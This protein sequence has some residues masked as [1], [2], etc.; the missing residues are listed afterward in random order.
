MARRINF[1]LC[2]KAHWALKSGKT[3]LSRKGHCLRDS[4]PDLPEGIDWKQG[5]MHYLRNLIRSE[6]THNELYHLIEP[7]LGGPDFQ[8][9]FSEMYGFLNM[10]EKANL[11]MKASILDVACDRAGRRRSAKL[12]HSVFGIDISDDL[13]EI[14]RRRIADEPFGVFEGIRPARPRSPCTTS[15]RRRSR[16]TARTG[17]TTRRLRCHVHHFVDPVQALRHV[18]ASLKDSGIVM[19]LGGCGTAARRRTLPAQH[20]AG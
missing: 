6:G 11:P 14:A 2:L 4:N 20:R 12:G 18:V 10:L 17:D 13:L 15:K 3:R 8:P 9:F 16:R 19:R 5:A 1:P 7:Y